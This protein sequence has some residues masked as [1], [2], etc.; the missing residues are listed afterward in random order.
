M[1][2]NTQSTMFSSKSMA[3]ETPKYLFDKLNKEFNFTLDAAASKHN[4]KCEKFFTIEDNAL[5]QDWSGNVVFC[6][7]PYGRQ[8]KHWIKKF[9]EEGLKPNTT[10]V[11]LIPSRTDTIYFHNYCMKAEEIRF[12]KGRLKFL[13]EEGKELAPAPFPSMIVV[14]DKK[15]HP[16]IKAY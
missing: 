4:A 6:N 7:P 13:N 16:E 11:A 5:S 15:E 8:L 9:Y 1:D 14:F 12:I 2:K 10:V 3:W